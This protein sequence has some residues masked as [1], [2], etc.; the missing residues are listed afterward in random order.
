M[1][2]LVKLTMLNRFWLIVLRAYLVAASRGSLLAR[3][4]SCPCRPVRFVP[5]AVDLKFIA[6]GPL[7]RARG[8]IAR[9]TNSM[10]TRWFEW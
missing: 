3:G 8:V 1:L 4:P 9:L 7:A 6:P 10:I 2:P 5:A